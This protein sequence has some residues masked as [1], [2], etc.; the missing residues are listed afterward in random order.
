MEEAKVVHLHNSQALIQIINA[1]TTYCTWQRG[2]GKTGGGIGPRFL[3]LSEVMPR[4]QVL[5]FSDTYDRLKKRIVPNII[6]FLQNK[7]GLIENIDFVKYVKPPEYFEN[8]LI[9]IDIYEHVVSFSSGMALCLVSLHVEGSAN[10][11]NAQAAIGDEVKYCD[12][13]KIFTEVLPAIRGAQDIFGHLP[14][15]LSVW[16][17][18]D[19]WGPKVKWLLQIRDKLKKDKLNQ[20]AIDTV[21]LLQMEIFRLEALLKQ[22]KQNDNINAYYSVKKQFE[23]LNTKANAIRKNLVY[24][25]DMKPYENESAL[26][27]VY[28]KRQK[29]I[30]KSEME[31]DVAILN[32]DPDKVESCYYPTLTDGNKYRLDNQEDYDSDLPFYVAFDYN[33]KIAPM[34]AVQISNKILPYFTTVNFID[35][36]FTLY[37]QGLKD[38]ID[39]FCNKYYHHNNKTIH[40][41]YDHTAIGRNAL[42]TTFK[43]EVI[44]FFNANE[45]DVI[46]HYIGQAP[47]HNLK[48][49]LFKKVLNHRGN[50][51]VLF[52]ESTTDPLLRSMGFTA[53]K[54]S[55]DETKKDKS[56][57]NDDNWPAE[58]APHFGDA[59]DM[60]LYAFFEIDILNLDT[61]AGLGI[62]VG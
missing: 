20:K 60:L 17:F 13:P 19:K 22:H 31:Y 23:N 21:Y 44:S 30:C 40:Y 59:A 10:A 58:D 28:F 47:A 48:Y 11:Y 62:S 35:A 25:S 15:Y 43:D 16:M 54:I 39:A 18:T 41:V 34:P 32:K 1:N 56:T 51:S 12:R 26:G 49:E 38:T 6:E 4:S 61:K 5:L 53:A 2:G 45:W 7:L 27:K 46:E 24:F 52:N 3:H 50:N 36:P 14:E 37:P 33:F 55:G 29:R 57:E 9:P 42:K 8:P